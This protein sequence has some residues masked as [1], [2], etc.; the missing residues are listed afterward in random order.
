MVLSDDIDKR[1]EKPSMHPHTFLIKKA[2]KIL[3]KE[4]ELSKSPY[5]NSNLTPE[6]AFELITS[7][8]SGFILMSSHK[9]H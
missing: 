7:G 3:M 5:I 1:K 4:I 9:S 8:D 2:F 6:N